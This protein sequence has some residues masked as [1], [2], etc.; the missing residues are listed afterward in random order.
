MPDGDVGKHEHNARDE[1]DERQH[2]LDALRALAGEAPA[3]TT[4]PAGAPRIPATSPLSGRGLRLQRWRPRPWWLA[5]GAIACLVVLAAM[6]LPRLFHQP[7]VSGSVRTPNPLTIALRQ[8]GLGCPYDAA[9][10]PDGKELAV[11]AH[12]Q[13]CSGFFRAAVYD[14]TTGKLL[15]QL[16]PSDLMYSTATTVRPGA[17]SSPDALYIDD[18]LWSPDGR[19]LALPFLTYATLSASDNPTLV[20]GLYVSDRDGSHAQAYAT[21]A[22]AAPYT[23][24]WNLDSGIQP[25]LAQMPPPALGYSWGRDGT[26]IANT[27]LG[28]TAPPAPPLGSVG[29]P[30]GNSPFTIWQPGTLTFMLVNPNTLQAEPPG[31]FSYT[32]TFAAWSP[33][34]RFFED[35]L[36]VTA[37]LQPAT[38]GAPSEQSLRDFGLASAP[39]LPVRDTALEHV[40]EAGATP[41]SPSLSLAWRPDGLLLATRPLGGSGVSL[42]DCASGQLMDTL[43]S[44]APSLATPATATATSI[45]DAIPNAL[46]WSPDGT[47]LLALNGAAS[48]ITIWGPGVLPK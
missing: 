11:L 28:G 16:R 5:L 22:P 48:S 13:R 37:R 7:T 27:P 29:A 44:A 26:L 35:G 47:H 33:D 9:W 39:L 18:I 38:L 36:G 14:A 12:D 42:Y 4:P 30:D 19:R 6:L 3:T 34:G 20:F 32:T 40:L 2:R 10:S 8:D 15:A 41:T 25:V 17:T 31:A 23:A 45:T 1:A 21:L 46:R 43:A 24:V